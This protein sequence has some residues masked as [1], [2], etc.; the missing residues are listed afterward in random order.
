[1]QE[2]LHT[3]VLERRQWKGK[4]IVINDNFKKKEKKWVDEF[5]IDALYEGG[6]PFNT[7]NKLV[8]EVLPLDAMGEDI[9]HLPS[10]K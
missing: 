2:N 10:I 1:M 8:V 3:F 4:Q 9:G 6:L 7:V 5:F